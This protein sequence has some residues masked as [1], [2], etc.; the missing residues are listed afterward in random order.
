M[1]LYGRPQM[2]ESRS[3][4]GSRIFSRNHMLL[5]SQLASVGDYLVSIRAGTYSGKKNVEG[6][7]CAVGDWSKKSSHFTLSASF[8][9][10]V[11]AV[12]VLESPA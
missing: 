7:G 5:N 6:A 10:M 3:L 1:R 8:L 12:D 11:M 4:I 9:A 2:G